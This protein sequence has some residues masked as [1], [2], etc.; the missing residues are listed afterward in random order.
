MIRFPLSLRNLGEY[1]EV[2]ARAAEHQTE[3]GERDPRV[4]GALRPRLLQAR[5]R[6]LRFLIGA[7]DLG[8]QGIELRSCNS[9]PMLRAPVVERPRLFASP[10][11]L[12]IRRRR[13]LSGVVVGAKEHAA[14]VVY[15]R[16]I[17]AQL[18]PFMRPFPC[19]LEFVLASE[20]PTIAPSHR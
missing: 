6:P 14:C 12:C 20:R 2:R 16:D 13:G 9:I 18:E 19:S 8:L 11:L 4:R 5:R 17:A 3:C 15:E 7:A 10:L 1:A